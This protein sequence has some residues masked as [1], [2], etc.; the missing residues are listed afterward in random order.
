MASPAPAIPT[1]AGWDTQADGK[2]TSYADGAMVRS[3][4]A[5]QGGTVTLY[6]Q[7]EARELSVSLSANGGILGAS[8][9]ATIAVPLGGK[10]TALAG[11]PDPTRDKYTFTGWYLTET[12]GEGDTA[13]TSGSAVATPDNHTLYAGRLGV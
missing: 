13:I 10:Y 11:V 7:W 8:S 12:P 9:P 5:A 3:L 2:G 1:F 4:S 6:A